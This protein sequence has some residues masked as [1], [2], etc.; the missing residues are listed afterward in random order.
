V[1]DVARLTFD[2]AIEFRRRAGRGGERVCGAYTLDR[3][4]RVLLRGAPNSSKVVAIAVSALLAACETGARPSAE[5]VASASGH[6]AI[7]TTGAG[8]EASATSGAPSAA[9][10]HDAKSPEPQC[11]KSDAPSARRA[12]HKARAKNDPEVLGG[13]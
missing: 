8:P 7:A 6:V 3:D 11:A 13:Y 5:P 12:T 9:P 1:V 2:E 4:S 10:A